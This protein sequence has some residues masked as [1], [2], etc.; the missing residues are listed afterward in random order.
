[1]PSSISFFVKFEAMKTVY[2]LLLLLFCAVVTNA[3]KIT[4]F[5]SSNSN[6]PKENS[7]SPIMVADSIGN[8]W[9]FRPIYGNYKYDG[10]EFTHID[11]P[12]KYTSPLLTDREG[13]VWF[14][15]GSTIIKFDGKNWV[16]YAKEQTGIKEIVITMAES[17]S[18]DLYAGTYDGLYYMHNNH[19][20]QVNL[21]NSDMYQYTIRCI[22]FGPENSMAVGCN[23]GL[24]LFD[25]AKWKK[26]NEYNSKLQLSVVR[27]L[28][29]MPTGELYIG[30]D[31]GPRSGG[32]SVL[33]KERWENYDAHNSKLP[34]QSIKDIV[35]TPNNVIWMATGNGLLKIEGN[36]WNVIKL[37]KSDPE[38]ISGLAAYHNILWVATTGELIKYE[39]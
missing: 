7:F 37:T 18:G 24:L 6:L 26:L 21:P 39:E 34:D 12:D 27:A 29:Y 22:D 16:K 14:H 2:T 31:G 32:F 4:V 20:S 13:N 17:P 1:M 33:K 3:Q 5:N 11:T 38:Y 8:V 36:K 19:W 35:F 25:G 23:D 9:L 28:K 15:N 10:H 30:Y